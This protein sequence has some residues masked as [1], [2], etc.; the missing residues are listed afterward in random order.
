MGTAMKPKLSEFSLRYLI[1]RQL[2][3]LPTFRSG[4]AFD[5]FPD[6]NTWKAIPSTSSIDDSAE[7]ENRLQSI[8]VS[9]RSKFDL[10]V[11]QQAL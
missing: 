8:C 11:R 10:Q 5:L 9:L 6:G 3:H 1:V 2:S 7:C 4:F